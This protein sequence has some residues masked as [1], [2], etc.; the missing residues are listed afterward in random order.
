MKKNIL[1]IVLTL[2][3]CLF[4]AQAQDVEATLKIISVKPAIV[5]IDG[6]FNNKNL[7]TFNWSFLRDYADVS[8]IGSRFSNLNLFDE[9]GNK[10]I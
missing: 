4:N 7:S 5:K 10:I 3:F 6:K 8:G 9:K 2:L 1:K